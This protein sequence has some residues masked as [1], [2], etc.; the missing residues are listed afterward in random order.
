VTPKELEGTVTSGDEA[1]FPGHDGAWC[2]RDSPTWQAS[3]RVGVLH[4]LEPKTS[5]NNVTAHLPPIA[6][7]FCCWSRRYNGPKAGTR[8]DWLQ[9]YLKTQ[10]IISPGF[11][12]LFFLINTSFCGRNITKKEKATHQT[13][14]LKK[15]SE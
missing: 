5:L 14:H 4:T 6:S 9:R 2:S 3:E 8:P 15:R 1:L 13:K 10:L 7:D 12:T 11:C